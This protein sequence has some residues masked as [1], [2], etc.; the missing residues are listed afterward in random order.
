LKLIRRDRAEN[1]LD[2]WPGGRNVVKYQQS[3]GAKKLPNA[4]EL[5]LEVITVMIPVHEAEIEPTASER[6]QKIQLMCT[7]AFIFP[8]RDWIVAREDF[9]LIAHIL[10]Q[11][12]SS[13]N[14]NSIL[15][16]E[17]V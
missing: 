5:S 12:I 7:R 2:L 17:I 14:C 3:A 1:G 6:V 9:P 16:P 8:V 11:G 4:I 10:L 15:Q 13:K